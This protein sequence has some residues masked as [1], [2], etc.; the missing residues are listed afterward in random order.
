MPSY[1][2]Y[3]T[4]LERGVERDLQEQWI[5][6]NLSAEEQ[7]SFEAA[8]DANILL[9]NSYL[10]QG[11]ITLEK[12]YE[13]VYVPEVGENIDVLI[14]EKLVLSAGASPSQLQIHPDLAQWMPRL[15]EDIFGTNIEI[16]Y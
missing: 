4:S 13:T 10:T 12:L 5:Q 15:P 9:W 11:L 3:Y 14:G 1:S 2:R 16:D 8:R 6:D 7:S